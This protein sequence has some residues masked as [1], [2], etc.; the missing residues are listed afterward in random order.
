VNFELIK[1]SLSAADLRRVEEEFE[2]LSE[3]EQLKIFLDVRKGIAS[4]IGDAQWEIETH[5]DEIRS[6]E[7]DIQALEKRDKPIAKEIQEARIRLGLDPV[8]GQLSLLEV[9]S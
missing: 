2:K 9:A 8:P 5:E 4:E 6:L 3:A 7:D 1:D